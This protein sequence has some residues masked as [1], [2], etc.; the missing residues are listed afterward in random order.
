[1]GKKEL[2][3][4]LK[5]RSNHLKSSSKKLDNYDKRIERVLNKLKKKRK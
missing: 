5:Q 2:E 3:K 1:M 4:L